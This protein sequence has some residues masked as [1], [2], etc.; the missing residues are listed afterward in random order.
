[1]ASKFFRGFSRVFKGPQH[2]GRVAT[3]GGVKPKVGKPTK[4]PKIKEAIKIKKK[5]EKLEK[6]SEAGIKKG[7]TM[8]ARSDMV[9]PTKNLRNIKRTKREADKFVK[10]TMKDK[11]AKGGMASQKKPAK[12][13]PG[14]QRDS[15]KEKILPKKKKAKM[16]KDK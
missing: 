14:R 4:A 7:K 5:V 2:K 6:S 12:P 11:F 8:L 1:M 16:K 15:I 3:I 10:E 9:G 13:L